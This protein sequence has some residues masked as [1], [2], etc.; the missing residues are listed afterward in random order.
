MFRV[1]AA[2]VSVWVVGQALDRVAEGLSVW[3]RAPLVFAAAKLTGD[4]VALTVFRSKI[5]L[6]VE[7]VVWELAGFVVLGVVAAGL[8]RVTGSLIGGPVSPDLPAA[9]VYVVYLL[10]ESRQR[11]RAGGE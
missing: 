4:L 6:F 1:G 9:I 8:I 5:V 10:A 2:I 7:D 11:D 3:V